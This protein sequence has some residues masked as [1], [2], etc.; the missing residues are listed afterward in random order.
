MTLQKAYDLEVDINSSPFLTNEE[1][2][3][4]QLYFLQLKDIKKIDP[5]LQKQNSIQF[6]NELEALYM[7][8][9][10]NSILLI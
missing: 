5:Y 8:M 4:L 1:K 6:L 7:K 9:L 3:V 2:E 10:S